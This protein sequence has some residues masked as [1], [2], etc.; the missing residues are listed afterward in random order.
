MISEK[1]KFN[2]VHAGFTLIELLV[3]I[4]IITILTA[5]LIPSLGRARE[6]ARTA[7]CGANLRSI[8]QGMHEYAAENN[9]ALVGSAWTS[10]AEMFYRL[11]VLG[12]S[13]MAGGGSL[14]HTYTD[15]QTPLCRQWGVEVTSGGT[16]DERV[17]RWKTIQSHKAFICPTMAS[18]D[19]PSKPL[20]AHPKWPTMRLNSYNTALL[21]HLKNNPGGAPF[22]GIR[23]GRNSGGYGADW[24]PPPEYAPNITKIERPSSK[25]FVGDGSRYSSPGTNISDYDQSSD[26]SYG[27]PFGDQGPFTKFSNSWDRGLAPGNGG[28]GTR[29]VRLLSFRHSWGAQ[30]GSAANSFKGNFA[31]F[32]GHVE[33][34]GDLQ[35]ANP[36]LWLPAGSE[37]KHDSTQM[38]PDV[39]EKYF[40]GNATGTS[41]ID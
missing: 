6:Q 20:I 11:Q 24:N 39:I 31:F 38:Y 30:K 27:G 25:I 9:G 41:F 17:A 29:D 10:G 15:W 34:L 16:V 2:R 36:S 19:I 21:F 32:D 28:T 23:V 22:A 35:A 7:V 33:L 12:M 13:E 18:M 14:L 40:G 37:V 3:V 1:M 4:G 8:A 26:S 5:I